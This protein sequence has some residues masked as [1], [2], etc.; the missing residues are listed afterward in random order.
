MLY[1]VK[2]VSAHAVFHE[3]D[4]WS[5]IA[6]TAPEPFKN[7]CCGVSSRKQS[8]L[9]KGKWGGGGGAGVTGL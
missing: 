5:R 2:K 1:R 3:T 7:C 9:I 8:E 6:D 4:C